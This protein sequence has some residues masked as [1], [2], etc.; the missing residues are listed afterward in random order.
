VA[1]AAAIVVINVGA[2]V[3]L[4]VTA[5]HGRSSK[6][7]LSVCTVSLFSVSLIPLLFGMT[8]PALVSLSLSLSVFLFLFLSNVKG[9]LLTWETYICIAKASVK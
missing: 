5:L 2:V 9:A 6:R 1:A 7:T 8:L 3:V 4:I